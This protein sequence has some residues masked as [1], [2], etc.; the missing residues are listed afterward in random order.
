M[1]CISS[2]DIVSVV[3]NICNIFWVFQHPNVHPNGIKT[4]L[5]NGLI[6]FFI[7]GNPNF[8]NGSRSLPRNSPGF[9][10]F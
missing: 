1:P 2:S 3:F 4:L 7:N 5:S 6:A 9:I 10:A 8:S